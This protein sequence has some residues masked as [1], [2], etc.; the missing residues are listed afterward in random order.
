MEHP[1]AQV[2]YH[3]YRLGVR[4]HV[5][6]LYQRNKDTF[7]EHYPTTE[8]DKYMNGQLITIG[9][10]IVRKCIVCE[11]ARELERFVSKATNSSGCGNTCDVCR[12]RACRARYLQRM[13]AKVRIKP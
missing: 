8:I 10:H 7:R 5:A 13:A 11:T 2:Q 3:M 4:S 9:E 12:G 1:V 6:M